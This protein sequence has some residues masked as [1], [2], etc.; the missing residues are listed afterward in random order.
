MKDMMA[1][2]AIMMLITS[3]TFAAG[4]QGEVIKIEDTQITIE[5][6]GDETVSFKEG[7]HVSLEAIPKNVPTLD[8]LQG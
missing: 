8:M 7:V 3:A 1:Q 4:F 2:F 6:F 5:V